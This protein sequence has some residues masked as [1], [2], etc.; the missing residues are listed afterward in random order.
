MTD[1]D[2][3]ALL[4]DLASVLCGG[5][6][7]DRDIMETDPMPERGEIGLTLSD[8]STVVLRVVHADV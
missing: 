1:S 6:I 3:Q 8:G 2:L 5:E 4:T 7:L